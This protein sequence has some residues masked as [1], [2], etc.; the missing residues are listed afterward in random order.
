MITIIDKNGK[1]TGVQYESFDFTPSVAEWHTEQGSTWVDID[2]LTPIRDE[3]GNFII[4]ED[5]EYD[6][7]S[8]TQE[9]IDA[10]AQ[11]LVD[12]MRAEVLPMALIEIEAFRASDMPEYVERWQEYYR[13]VY[14]MEPSNKTSRIASILPP[15]PPTL[16]DVLCS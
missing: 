6:Y 3:N 12:E 1:F 4:G 15:T 13:L 9:Q 11:Q 14:L 16:K 7:G 2:K 5:G 10:Y 8:A